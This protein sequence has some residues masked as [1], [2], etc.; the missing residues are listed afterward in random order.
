M[1]RLAT[2]GFFRF[3]RKCF[4]MKVERRFHRC[5]DIKCPLCLSKMRT[6][7]GPFF[8]GCMVSGDYWLADY[9]ELKRTT[10]PSTI[11]SPLG[12]PGFCIFCSTVS[13][14]HFCHCN[15]ARV[16][17][18]WKVINPPTKTFCSFYKNLAGLL[19]LM[20]CINKLYLCVWLIS[21]W[22]W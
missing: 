11:G 16:R 20:R 19:I 22:V 3:C 2:N 6:P 14:R 17:A 10:Q 18:D 21:W 7:F 8:I 9:P 13:S 12:E 5:T 1:V 4:G 15:T